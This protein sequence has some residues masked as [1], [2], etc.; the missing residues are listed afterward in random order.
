M[1]ASACHVWATLDNF[2]Q[3]SPWSL[4][5]GQWFAPSSSMISWAKL[6]CHRWWIWAQELIL[7]PFDWPPTS[8]S[9]LPMRWTLP[10]CV[11]LNCSTGIQLA[12]LAGGGSWGTLCVS[13]PYACYWLLLYTVQLYSI[14]MYNIFRT[15]SLELDVFHFRTECLPILCQWVAS[16]DLLPI[17]AHLLSLA[18]CNHI[19]QL[20]SFIFSLF[21]VIHVAIN[22]FLVIQVM[23][24]QVCLILFD[25][26]PISFAVR[27]WQLNSRQVPQTSDE[28]LRKLESLHEPKTE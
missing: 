6:P 3:L 15:V 2:G 11:Q 1:F 27:K 13:S 8:A 26:S 12:Y 28:R 24:H 17:T 23:H 21:L 25:C 10:K 5:C 14:M 19:T 4:R 9:R 18:W 7:G 22:L 16:D 20:G